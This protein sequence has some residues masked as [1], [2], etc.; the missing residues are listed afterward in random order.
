MELAGKDGSGDD[1]VQE[2]SLSG[3]GCGTGDLDDGWRL[4]VIRCLW[5]WE[6]RIL[7]VGM[8]VVLRALSW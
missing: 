5:W 4:L 8:R 1:E 3:A 2:L 6:W 7:V